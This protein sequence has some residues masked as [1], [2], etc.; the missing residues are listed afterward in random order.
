MMFCAIWYHLGNVKNVQ[1]TPGRVL[2]LVQLQALASP[3]VFFT[4]CISTNGTKSRKASYILDVDTKSA[5]GYQVPPQKHHL[6]LSRQARPPTLLNLQPVQAPLFRQ[7][8][9]IHCFLWTP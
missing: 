5:L 6:P 7:S 8:P 2:F 9:F 1:N 4:F 3:Y